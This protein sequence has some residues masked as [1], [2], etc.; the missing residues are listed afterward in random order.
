[1]HC[2]LVI[3]AV[4]CKLRRVSLE[5]VRRRLE[6]AKVYPRG[7]HAGLGSEFRTSLDMSRTA[8]TLMNLHYL[9]NP[10]PFS[11]FDPYRFSP[12]KLSFQSN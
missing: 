5:T 8:H 12:S 10:F 9:L 7:E 11:Y 1:M 6:V 2:Y 4:F 3:T